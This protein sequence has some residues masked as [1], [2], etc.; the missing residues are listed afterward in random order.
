MPTVGALPPPPQMPMLPPP[1]GGP[2]GGGLVGPGGPG[3][4]PMATR[5]AEDGAKYGGA[6]DNPVA[7]GGNPAASQ[8]LGGA[9]GGALPPQ[10]M[11]LVQ[12]LMQR[13]RQR[14]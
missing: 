10:L 14:M 8:G 12:Q 5:A 7:R 1:M 6:R 9:P 13:Q 4:T 11:Q 2:Q 3:R